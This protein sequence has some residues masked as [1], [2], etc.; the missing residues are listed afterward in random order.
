MTTMA[1]EKPAPRVPA[2]VGAYDRVFYSGMAIAMALTVFVGFAPSYYLRW[3]AGG[4]GA[5]IS[6][7]PLSPLVHLHGA[8]FTAWVVLFV[9]QTGLVAARRVRVH[10]R[11]GIAG[12]VLAA[13]MFV[14]GITTAI[15]GARVG[16]GPAGV[17]PLVFLVVPLFDILLFAG[18]VTAAMVVRRQ[19]EAHKR[20]MLL[21]Y[22]S[23]LPAA[24][25]RLPGVLSL[26][27]MGFFGLTLVFVLLA[28]AYDLISRRRVHKVYVLGGL[29]LAAAAPGRLMLSGTEVWRMF[30]GWLVG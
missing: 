12:A 14:V 22:V 30:A 19:K 23:I 3:L 27:P 4:A 24:V 25:A 15:S 18:F 17:D 28:V 21:A 20:L 2:V 8:V 29:L 11:L 6:G 1:A 5:T 10:R 9:V 26:G 16:A 7:R 13:V